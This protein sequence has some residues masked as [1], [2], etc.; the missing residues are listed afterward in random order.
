[1]KRQ[2][3]AVVLGGFYCWCGRYFLRKG[4]LTRHRRAYHPIEYMAQVKREE[5]KL[6]ARRKGE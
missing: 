2:G 6:R 1:M 4:G 5:R 3:R